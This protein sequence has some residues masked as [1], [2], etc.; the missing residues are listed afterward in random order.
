MLRINS[1]FLD[2]LGF[3]RFGQRISRSVSAMPNEDEVPLL[4]R[5]FYSTD[6]LLMNCSTPDPNFDDSLSVFESASN[7]RSSIKSA[8]CKACSNCVELEEKVKLL[9][10]QV[11]RYEHLLKA[12]PKVYKWF[13]RLNA[14][15][16]QKNVNGMSMVYLN[17]P[18]IK[19]TH[20]CD[21]I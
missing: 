16:D 2:S 5:S 18:S 6:N 9:K 11:A 1:N 12:A 14:C 21:Y 10:K 15:M 17:K 3:D 4:K 7:E 19:I 13:A 8:N 20:C